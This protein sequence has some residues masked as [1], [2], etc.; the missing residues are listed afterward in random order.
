LIQTGPGLPAWQWRTFALQWNGPVAASQEVRLW[1]VPP[2]VNLALAFLRV[3]CLAGLCVGLI[4]RRFWRQRLD[5]SKWTGSAAAV[6]MLGMALCTGVVRAESRPQGFPPAPLLEELKTRLLQKPDCMPACAEVGRLDLTTGDGQLRL[7]LQIHA[8]CNAAVPLPVTAASW[9]PQAVVI[10]KKPAK[11]VIRG[12]DGNL[13]TMVPQGVH[14]VVLSGPS[15]HLDSIQLPLPLKPRQVNFSLEGWSVRGVG[16]DGRGENGLQLVRQGPPTA[17]ATVGTGRYLPPFLHVT[18]ELRLGLSWQ[19]VTTIRRL[20]A[21]E[22][23]VTLSLPLLSGE[24]VVTPGIPVENGTAQ[25]NLPSGKQRLSFSSDLPVSDEIRLKAPD[26]VSWSEIWRLDAGS[27]WDCRL[28]GIAVVHHQDSD[29]QWRPEW[30]PWPGEEVLIKVSRPQPVPG[31]Q[32]TIDAAR[33]EWTPGKRLDRSQLVLDLRS[34]RGGQH[35]LGLPPT[36]ELQ[37]VAIDGQ[38]LPLKSAQ[39]TLLVPLR[40]GAQTVTVAWQQESDGRLLQRTPSVVIGDAAVNAA[41]TIRLPRSRWLLWAH[42]PRLGPAVLFWSFLAV[43]VML[44]LGLGRF[45]LTPL[46]TFDWLLL[47]L[48]L[49]QIPV[50]VAL[51]VAGWLM[52]LGIRQK[53]PPPESWAVFNGV[54]VGLVGWTVLALGGLYL[55]IQNGLLGI[56]EMQVAGNFSSL[57]ELN[58]YQDRIGAKMPQPWVLSLPLW[59]YRLLMLLW[60]LWLAF[61]LLKWLRWGWSCWNAG[62][63]WRKLRRQKPPQEAADAAQG[64]AP[65]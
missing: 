22:F 10:D 34:S 17:A 52:A 3:L 37:Q 44:A 16:K 46:R 25:I 32:V 62:G 56:P 28:M 40:P 30:R 47:V 27:I 13:W 11:G 15:G 35:A 24:A 20:T 60:S 29:G 42:G 65:Q 8:G 19:V 12:R 36:A 23:P 18:R 45:P 26:G 50:P 21:P 7:D 41:V 58:W 31:R 51:G 38:S 64:G 4:D 61:S 63:W 48:G 59:V 1:L 33:L 49:T 55:A 54:Q 5:F 2:G 6:L 43:V 14:R 53:Y 9:L 39:G 57:F